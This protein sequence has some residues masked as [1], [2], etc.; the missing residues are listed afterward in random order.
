MLDVQYQ[1]NIA[2]IDVR[3]RIR[4]GEHPKQEIVSF[5]KEA[6]QGTIVE[7]HLPHQAQPLVNAL[8]AIG[9]QAIMNALSPDHYRMMCVKL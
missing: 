2:V 1:G 5:I 3:D 6:K 4:R 7:I 9:I 8:E